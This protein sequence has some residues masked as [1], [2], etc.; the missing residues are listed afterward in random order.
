MA[1]SSEY[2]A[3]LRDAPS[4][5]LRMRSLEHRR[6]VQPEMPEQLDKR[7]QPLAPISFDIESLVIEEAS[8]VAQ[9]AAALRH[10]ALDDL[11]RGVTLAAKRAAEIAARVIK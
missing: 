6:P 9:A 3:I 4:A 5:L 11:R 7:L 8:A 10:V 1:T 2:A